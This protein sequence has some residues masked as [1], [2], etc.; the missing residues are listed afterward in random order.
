[1]END[2]SESTVQQQIQIEGPNHGC[3]LQR[4]NSGSLPGLDGRPVRFGLGN[5]SKRQNDA[6]K[7]SDLIGIT[8]ITITPDMVGRK[9]GVFT[10]VEVKKPDWKRSPTDKRERAQAAYIDWV[11]SRGGFAGFANCIESFRRLL[12]VETVTYKKPL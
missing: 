4:N 12:G 8:T 1:M 5:T 7:S 11:I 10:A 6:I 9:I 3:I 2:N